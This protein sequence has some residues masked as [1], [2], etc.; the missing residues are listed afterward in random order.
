MQAFIFPAFNVVVFAH[1]PKKV[2]KK[3]KNKSTPQAT[4]AEDINENIEIR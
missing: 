2:K 1:A 3:I 4:E